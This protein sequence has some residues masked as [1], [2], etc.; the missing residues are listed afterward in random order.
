MET[1]LVCTNGTI[2]D[3]TK[4]LLNIEQ[5]SLCLSILSSLVLRQEVS[6]HAVGPAPP[7]AVLPASA[8]LP[9]YGALPLMPGF[10]GA[11]HPAGPPPGHVAPAAA[12]DWS[13]YYYVSV[14]A[15][16]RRRAG[17]ARTHISGALVPRCDID[18]RSAKRCRC[19]RGGRQ[20]EEIAF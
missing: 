14:G 2:A 5:E 7:P 12:T 18:H 6:L 17:C 1:P 8:V 16:L 11:A 13:A 9:A 3:Q 10:L 20:V 15:S 4:G 19:A